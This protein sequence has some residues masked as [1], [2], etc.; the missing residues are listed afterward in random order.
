MRKP[1]LFILFVLLI[2]AVRQWEQRP[3]THPPEAWADPVSPEA[4]ETRPQW[5]RN[6]GNDLQ[7]VLSRVTRYL[8]YTDWRSSL[9]GL[10]LNNAARPIAGERADPWSTDPNFTA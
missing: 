3:L 6:A 7:F 8:G 1:L 4:F 9:I 10:T 5:V 2:L